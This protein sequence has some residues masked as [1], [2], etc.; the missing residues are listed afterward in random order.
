MGDVSA[1]GPA[2]DALV[3]ICPRHIRDGK[4]FYDPDC[5]D[6]GSRQDAVRIYLLGLI[7]D[8]ERALLGIQ[9]TDRATDAR[10]Q[11]GEISE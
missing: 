6:C 4:V 2:I 7:E 1:Y 3:A 10:R 8:V 11:Q 5:G 9:Q